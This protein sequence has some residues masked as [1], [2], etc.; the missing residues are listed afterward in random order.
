MKVEGNTNATLPMDSLTLLEKQLLKLH[1]SLSKR[2]SKKIDH[3]VTVSQFKLLARIADGANTVS[4]IAGQL[5]VSAAAASKMAEC[6]VEADLVERLRSGADRR[7]VILGLTK[8]GQEVLEI[9]KQYIGRELAEI[10]GVLTPQELNELIRL[11]EK[12]LNTIDED[13]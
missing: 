4:E 2:I 5:Q 11:F 13:F 1:R 8:Q 10:F 6:L 9:N 3:E 7:V 12:V